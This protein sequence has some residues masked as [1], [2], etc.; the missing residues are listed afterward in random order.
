[1]FGSSR[2]APHGNDPSRRWARVRGVRLRRPS[3]R[4]ARSSSPPW[5]R[6]TACVYVPLVEHEREDGQQDVR[7][8][9]AT[10]S[11]TA[12]YSTPLSGGLLL[13]YPVGWFDITGARIPR[14]A[15]TSPSGRRSA[16]PGT[17]RTSRSSARTGVR[18]RPARAALIGQALLFGLGAFLLMLTVRRWWG[19]GVA[20]RSAAALRGR[21]VVEA[22]RRAR[23]ERDARREPS[24]SPAAT[25]SRVRGSDRHVALVGSAPA[26]S[27]GALTLVRAVF[28]FTVPLL[29]VLAAL[30]RAGRRCERLT[31]RGR[32]GC[33]R[34]VL[35]V[36]WLAWT[37]DVAGRATMS[38]LGR[39][40]QPRRSPR[41]AR[42]TARPQAEVEAD[43]AFQS[44]HGPRPGAGTRRRARARSR[45]DG[46]PALP[47]ARGRAGA[48]TTRSSCTAS[49]SADEPLD[50]LWETSTACGSSGTRTRT[51]TSRRVPRSLSCEA[52]DVLVLALALV[53]SVLALGAAARRARS[54]LPR[55]LHRRARDAPRRGAV[56]DAAA[57]PLSRARDVALALLERL[58]SVAR[59][60]QERRQPE[61]RRRRTSDRGHERLRPAEHE[62]GGEHAER[63]GRDASRVAVETA[64][65]PHAAERGQPEEREQQRQRR[66]PRAEGRRRRTRSRRAPAVKL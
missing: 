3:F 47:R 63:R 14:A 46:A 59:A 60:E 49:G 24:P 54:R 33:R 40:L 20:P 39:G 37:H 25:C 13:L 16:R 62:S 26:R 17:R 42:G 34:A 32:Y 28:V 65:E 36:P 4:R 15:G 61:R 45:P 9:R 2:S 57:R 66:R 51:G 11:S 22:L 52:L 38:R 55:R 12:S 18:R 5:P 30:V 53:G 35:L 21:P 44:R 48:A 1:M 10:R 58:R 29:L 8:L 31:A 6:C 7:R 43:P 56:R 50:V 19:R 23:A 27:A 41:A 64:D